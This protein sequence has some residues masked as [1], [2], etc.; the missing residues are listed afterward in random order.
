MI[1]RLLA[2]ANERKFIPRTQKSLLEDSVSMLNVVITARL[3]QRKEKSYVCLTLRWNHASVHI[4]DERVEQWPIQ[5]F[6]GTEQGS[7]PTH[8][9][10]HTTCRTEG[11][12]SGVTR[13]CEI[14][15]PVHLPPLHISAPSKAL[16]LRRLVQWRS[17]CALHKGNQAP[18]VAQ[19]TSFTS[20]FLLQFVTMY[21][22]T[23]C[24]DVVGLVPLFEGLF[25]SFLCRIRHMG[26]IRRMFSL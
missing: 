21:N 13:A 6:E 25:L 1:S 8:L 5:P 16:I 15:L 18:D 7:R 11:W 20:M 26:P 17:S 9:D 24:I 23:D 19:Y 4:D 22:N 12:S 3:V 14:K 10:H 2:M